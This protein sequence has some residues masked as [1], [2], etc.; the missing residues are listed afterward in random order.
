VNRQKRNNQG[1]TLI[2]LIIAIAIV[3]I[4]SS[5]ALGS[6]KDYVVRAKMS[7]PIAVLAEI[8]T[9][10]TEFS[11]I[12]GRPMTLAEAFRLQPDLLEGIREAGAHAETEVSPYVFAMPRELEIWAVVNASWL[13]DVDANF[14]VFGLS[15]TSRWDGSI[16]WVCMPYPDADIAMPDKYLPAN[17]RS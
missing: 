7:E 17:C 13:P 1:F 12:H 14:R 15:G 4:L 11:V 2:E 5:V 6:Y 9:T 16:E 8:K 3:G 10:L